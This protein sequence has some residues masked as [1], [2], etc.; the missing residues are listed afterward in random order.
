[1]G[2]AP[3]DTWGSIPACT[4]NP[5]CE[6]AR[7]Y[8]V[9][10][11]PR[12]YGESSLR[13]RCYVCP[14]GLS[15]RVRGIRPTHRRLETRPRSIPACTGNPGCRTGR[16]RRTWVYPRVY[17]E[18]QARPSGPVVMDGLSPRVRGIPLPVVL[19]KRG[20]GSIPA[21]TG[22]PTCGRPGALLAGVYPRVYGESILS[23]R[24]RPTWTG[25]SP[26]VRGI[27]G[28][29]RRRR[30]PGGSIPACTGN[31]IMPWPTGGLSRVYPRVYGESTSGTTYSA[32]AAGL[33][34]RVRGILDQHSRAGGQLGSIPACTGNPDR[35]MKNINTDWVY[36]RVYGESSRP[37][38]TGARRR[39]LSPRVR[40]IRTLGS[41]SR[42]PFGSIPACTGNPRACAG[43]RPGPRVYPR[44]YGESNR[45]RQPA[46]V[47]RGL[48]PRVRGIRSVL[49]TDP[50][51]KGSI[52]A[53]T[54]NP[55]SSELNASQDGVYPRVYGE[56]DSGLT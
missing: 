43:R 31:P 9:R 21:C 10:V 55:W 44:V 50:V 41:G 36:P 39:G 3:G 53:C 29:R 18:S 2:Y 6:L 52:P 15:P 46:Q 51:G 26:R 38:T 11:Y 1:M 32:G 33:S 48:S 37:S 42:V 40:G 27:H 8:R 4:G 14:R 54:G 56:S 5:H 30:R 13:T 28:D 20:R 12:V 47:A 24:P 23:R 7:S 35:N 49:G 45:R 22:N 16:R 19:S 25:L 34:P 17:G